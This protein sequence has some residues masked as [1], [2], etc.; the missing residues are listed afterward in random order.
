MDNCY[1]TFMQEA[2]WNC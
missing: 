1:I 2:L